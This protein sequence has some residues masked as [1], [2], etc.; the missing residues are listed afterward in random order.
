MTH[1]RQLACCCCGGGAIGR[2]WWNRDHGFGLCANCVD[3]CVGD[4]LPLGV[5]TE[6]YG[7]RGFHFDTENPF[8]STGRKGKKFFYYHAGHLAIDKERP[9]QLC[10]DF[11]CLCGQFYTT[12]QAEAALTAL[13][14]DKAAGVLPCN[15]STWDKHHLLTPEKP[16]A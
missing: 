16:P 14:A 10:S 9:W 7:V 8:M 12:A 2:Q 6:S 11:G 5:T 15:L 3:Y 4:D 1:T 13:E